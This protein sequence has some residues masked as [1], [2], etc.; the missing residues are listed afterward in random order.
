MTAPNY[1]SPACQH[2]WVDRCSAK[3]QNTIRCTLP[4]GHAGD[5]GCRI[6]GS[7]C[8]QW[9]T[10]IP[11]CAAVDPLGHNVCTLDYGSVTFF[12]ARGESN[13]KPQ[14]PVKKWWVSWWSP[15]KDFEMTNPWWTIGRPRSEGIQMIGAAVKAP[16]EQAV[17]EFVRKAYDTD[18]GDLVFESIQQQPDDWT[19]FNFVFVQ[20]DWMI[21]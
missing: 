16:T 4:E 19:P 17:K 5:H 9:S 8:T 13:F 7:I 21:W 6:A 20:K 11:R 2:S 18:P 15:W 14:P 1:L 10:K 3:Y 12:T